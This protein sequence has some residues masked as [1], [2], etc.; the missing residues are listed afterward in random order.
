MNGVNLGFA[1]ALALVF[2]V[3]P[4]VLA[5]VHL[6]FKRWSEAFLMIFPILLLILM[7][8]SG[9]RIALATAWPA[10]LA[11]CTVAYRRR[12][13][14]AAKGEA[15]LTGS[16]AALSALAAGVVNAEIWE[17]SIFAMTPETTGWLIGGA[18]CVLTAVLLTKLWSQRAM[19][20]Q[21]TSS[22]TA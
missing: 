6:R 11:G 3:V 22:T 18:L 1:A 17:I 20:T 9:T 4:L 15:V 19:Q 2:F 16:L 10:L 8:D 12:Y 14:L 13:R 7:Y 21:A 5:S